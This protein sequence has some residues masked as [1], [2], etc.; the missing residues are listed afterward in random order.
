MQEIFKN[1]KN[2][3]IVF[4]GCGFLI[5]ISWYSFF[6]KNLASEYEDI[7]NS[8][9]QLNRDIAKYKRMQSQV[10]ALENDWNNL[11]TD[12]KNTIQKIPNKNL[13]ENVADYLY[14]LVINHGL[15]IEK[16]SPSNSPI[17]KKTILMPDSGDEILVEKIDRKI[18]FA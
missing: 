17:D 14:S 2:V 13:Y 5:L 8:K 6:Y 18:I 3:F 10:N 12:F 11:N 7:T 9:N 4:F 16:F 1:Q 15:K